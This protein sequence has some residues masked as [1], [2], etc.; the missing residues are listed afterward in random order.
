MCWRW[1]IAGFSVVGNCLG[2]CDRFCLCSGFRGG[3]GWDWK[4]LVFWCLVFWLLV[5]GFG[6]F[7]WL[8]E[9]RV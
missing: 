9:F 6:V 5:L 2:C 8:C 7:V 3:F 4:S 1:L